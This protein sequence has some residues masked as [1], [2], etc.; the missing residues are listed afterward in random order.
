MSARQAIFFDCEFLV[1]PGAPQRFWCGPEDP[2]PQVV[3]IGAVALSLEPPFEIGERLD[4]RIRPHDR[5]GQFVPPEP[6]FTQLTGLS[7]ADLRAGL[8]LAEALR[9]F[10]TFCQGARVWSWGKDELNLMAIT[11]WLA[12]VA[13]PMRPERF[14]NA[15]ALVQKAGQPIDV[16][17]KTRSNALPEL[18]GLSVEGARAH[19]AVSDALSVAVPVQH[20]LREGLLEPVDLH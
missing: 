12:D 13:A 9:Q 20:L 1:S 15:A 5:A 7:D 10:E 6:I 16:I 8:P 4:L 17:H 3:Q 19:D 18:F 11:C 2:D 14:G